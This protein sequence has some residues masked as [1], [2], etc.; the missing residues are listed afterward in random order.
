[1][2]ILGGLIGA[3]R[4][5]V[6]FPGGTS[7]PPR[8]TLGIVPQKN[9]LIKGNRLSI[10]L[11]AKLILFRIVPSTN[12]KTLQGRQVVSEFGTRGE[13]GTAAA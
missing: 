2:S 4:G 13:F 1:L 7:T 6:A 9:V 12:S 8:G 3:S 5:V 10:D 11:L